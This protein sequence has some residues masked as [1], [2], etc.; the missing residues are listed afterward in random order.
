MPTV[1]V[2]GT[3]LYYER[4]GSGPSVLFIQGA[5]GDGGTF[6]QVA[7]LLADEFTIVTY[8]R[9]G[10]SRSP[11]PSGWAMTTMDEQA[12]DA[13]ALLRALDLA[14]AAVFGTSG[15]AV[16]LLNLLL[17]QPQV[18]RG[19]LVHEPPLI[20]VVPGGAAL[21]AQFQAM[22]EEALAKG[23]PRGAME[24]F[25]R[26]EA[27][28]ANFEH[29]EPAL[30]ERM[31]GNADVFFSTELEPLVTYVPDA[32]A[33]GQVRVPVFALAGVEH[34]GADS[35]PGDYHYEATRWVADRLGTN[36]M[37]LPGA[38]APYLDRP[39]E[40]AV[41]LRPLLKQVS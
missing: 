36:L 32:A 39:Q 10:N 11:R 8:D 2:N 9:R 3:Q 38:H 21:G 15:G 4:R 20:P 19:A 28:D 35:G 37:E 17:R 23:G 14:P 16:I 34:R 13:A 41:A 40:L 29:L 25:L 33:L 6:T 31:L 5:T 22:T 24:F 30:R 26:A 12:D 7:E 18:L 1:S 27:G